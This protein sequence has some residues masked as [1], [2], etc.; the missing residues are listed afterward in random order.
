MQ[1]K[2]KISWPTGIIIAIISFV[3][4][5]LSFVYKATFIPAY[6]HHLVSDDYYK[7]ELNYQQEIDNQN[8]GAKLKENVT[9]KKEASGLTIY[10]PSEF[11]PTQ[12][13]GTIYFQRPSNDKIDFNLP[14]KLITNKY[15]LTD[16]NL[17]EG[18]WNVKIEWTVNKNT[19]L[20]KEKIMY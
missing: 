17:V 10:F 2:F 19:Y 20:F 11:E 1:V 8:R 4:F 13:S 7:D 14:I 5:I 3:I 6:D 9:I 12:I 15:L 18:R 16:K